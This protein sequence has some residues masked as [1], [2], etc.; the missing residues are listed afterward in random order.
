MKTSFRTIAL[1][2]ALVSTVALARNDEKAKKG[3][4]IETGVYSSTD[5]TLHVNIEKSPTASASVVILNAD[6]DV[7]IREGIGKKQ[8]GVSFIFNLENLKDGKYELVVASQGKREVK[9]FTIQ[10]EKTI[11]QRRLTVE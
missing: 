4:S 3:A 8:T 6:G 9:E 2:L 5:G 1:A 10:S 11:T 7:L